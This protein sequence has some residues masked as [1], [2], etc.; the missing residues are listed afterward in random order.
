[1]DWNNIDANNSYEMSQASARKNYVEEIMR[2]K[3]I[4]LPFIKAKLTLWQRI[5]RM[6]R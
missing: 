2:E 1:M 5:K 3:P 6:I 4:E